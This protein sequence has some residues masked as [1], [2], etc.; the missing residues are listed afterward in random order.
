ML[1]VYHT[2]QMFAMLVTEQQLISLLFLHRETALDQ[3]FLAGE[4]IFF[5]Q[6]AHA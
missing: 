3:K 6:F 2:L 4:A 5:I 1:L